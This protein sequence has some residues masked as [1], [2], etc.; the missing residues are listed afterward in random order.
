[1]PSLRV[2]AML[3][4]VPPPGARRRPEHEAP[5]LP[6]GPTRAIAVLDRLRDMVLRGELPPGARLLEVPTAVRLGVSRTPVRIALTMLEAEGLLDYR[7]QVGFTVVPDLR[8]A[9]REAAEAAAALEA[10]A[11]RAAAAAVGLDGYGRIAVR[12]GGAEAVAAERDGSAAWR[13]RWAAADAAFHEAVLAAGAGAWRARL[14]GRLRRLRPAEPADVAAAA[15]AHLA[16]AAALAAGDGDAAWRLMHDHVLA[17][18]EPPPP[19]PPPPAPTRHAGRR[20]GIGGSA[21]RHRSA[22]GAADGR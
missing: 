16:I 11:A 19:A 22:R 21:R 6:G 14:A 2:S 3:R 18:A 5:P 1:M 17:E 15:A 13:R 20:T 7:P 9:L 12:A 8:D 4:S 10:D